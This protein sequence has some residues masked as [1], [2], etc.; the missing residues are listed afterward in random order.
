[1]PKIT[2]RV[3]DAAQADP[4]RRYFVWDTEISGFGLLV[5]P[6]GT[7]TYVYQYRTPEGRQRRATIGEHGRKVTADEARDKANRMRRDVAEGRD[8][9]GER[10][11]Q[12]Q[13]ATVA[14]VLD[15]YLASEAFAAKAPSTRATDEGRVRRHLRPLLGR[16]HIEKLTGEEISK[17]LAA[18]RDGKTAVDEKVGFRARARVTGGEGTARRTIR[19]FKAILAWAVREGRIKV[20]PAEHVDTGSD[21][22]RDT[23]LEDRDAY[24]RL[25]A[26]IGKLENEHRI[27]RPVADAIR[28]IA[29]TGARRGE[30]TGLRW[31]HVDLRKGLLVLPP[32]A[33][34]AGRRTGKPRVI[35]LPAAAQAIVARQPPGDAD[36]LVFRPSRGVGP[37][38]VQKPWAGIRAEANLPDGIGLHALRHSLAS[39]MAMGGAQAAEIMTALGHRDIGTSQKY[40]H[41]ALDARQALAE[42]AAGVALAGLSSADEVTVVELDARR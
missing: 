29:L 18:I 36:D 19:L 39:H 26:A 10:Q 8:P 40:V 38:A 12:R 23:I 9:L 33:H 37:L 3:V 35:G 14:D 32:A 6:T 42:R 17:A 13:A 20:N 21:G 24:A 4:T 25:F 30:I 15:A 31:A 5:L 27:R 41:W 28:V 16:K 11:A 34:K 22:A 2:K 7:K 1:M